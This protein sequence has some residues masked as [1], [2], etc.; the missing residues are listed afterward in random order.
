MFYQIELP[1][2][3]GFVDLA[4]VIPAFM[5]QQ[6]QVFIALDPWRRIIQQHI[7]LGKR[8]R[9]DHVTIGNDLRRF[10]DTHR[11]NGAASLAFAKA[12]PQK[13]CFFLVAFHQIDMSVLLLGQENRGNDPWKTAATSEVYPARRLRMKLKDLSAIS[14]M[15]A[16]EIIDGRRRHQI[17]G[18]RP[19][20]EELGKVLQPPLCFT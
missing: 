18:L 5:Q 2:T 8:P 15:P 12:N 3:T 17:D 4:F 20:L 13:R 11:M 7:Q 1:T 9:R 10:L 14:N 6:A 19:F 16:P